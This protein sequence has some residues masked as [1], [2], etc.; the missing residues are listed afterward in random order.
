[1]R[2]GVLA[3]QGGFE[4]HAEKL[5]GLGA[6]PF[7]IRNQNELDAIDGLILPGGESTTLLKVCSPEFRSAIKEKISSGLPTLATC[8]GLIFIAKQVENPPQESLGVLDIDVKR[9]AYGRQVDSFITSDLSATDSA[10]AKLKDG[11]PLE[12]VFIRAPKITRIGENVSVLLKSSDNPILVRQ[13]NILGAT[14]H[15]ELSQSS[16]AIHELFLSL[17]SH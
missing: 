4:L 16:A 15:P 1:M 12:A 6:N 9:N 14:F 2:V 5:R 11:A 17:I 3:L 7:L 13:G 10:P 8:A